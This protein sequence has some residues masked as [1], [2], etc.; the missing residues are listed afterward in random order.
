MP[1]YRIEPSGNGLFWTV[2][3]LADGATLFLQGDD[4]AQ[5]GRWLE[6]TWGGFTD[7]DVCDKY[8]DQFTVPI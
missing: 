2:T 6:S 3:R 8:A 5:F 4:A 7:D 1:K